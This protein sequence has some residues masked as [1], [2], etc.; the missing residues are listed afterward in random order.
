MKCNVWCG[1]ADVK[2]WQEG[3]L[4]LR[5]LHNPTRVPRALP[6]PR[7]DPALGTGM[8]SSARS[9][10]VWVPGLQRW[11]HGGNGLP[12]LCMSFHRKLRTAL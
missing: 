9:H 12:L 2:I 4:S 1:P 7:Q 5:D 10:Q 8:A 6:G 11:E 3:L